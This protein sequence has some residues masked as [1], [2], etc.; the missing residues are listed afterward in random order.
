MSFL[1]DNFGKI[2]RV[3]AYTDGAD[4]LYQDADTKNAF[5]G[6]LTIQDDPS[7]KDGFACGGSIVYFNALDQKSTAFW[8]HGSWMFEG[9][10]LVGCGGFGQGWLEYCLRPIDDKEIV[11]SNKYETE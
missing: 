5:P 1:S 7:C 3:E 11:M 6:H 2:I 4:G 8:Q 9:Y 10:Y